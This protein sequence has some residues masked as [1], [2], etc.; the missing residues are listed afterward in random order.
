MT[1]ID[2]TAER[3][4]R[5]HL[6]AV[7]KVESFAREVAAQHGIPPEDMAVL[8]ALVAAREISRQYQPEAAADVL[9]DFADEIREHPENWG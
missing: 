2:L 5:F 3:F 7:E 6:P 9:L 4:G 1:V 8:L